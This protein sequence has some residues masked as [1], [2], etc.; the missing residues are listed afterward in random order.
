MSRFVVVN[1]TRETKPVSEKGFGLPLMLA[2][3]KELD[4]KIYT[5][6]SEVAADFAETTREYKLASRMFG[7]S[8][9]IAELAC[10]GTSYVSE[11]DDVTALT[12][13]LNELVQI[14]N[15]FFYLV[16]PEN[17]DKEIKALAEWISTQE[18]FYGVT[19]QNVALVD[20]LK[21][22]YENTFLSVH[23]DP[24]A[25][26]AEGLIA[27]SAPKEIG[28]YTWTFKQINGVRA[29][30][31][32]NTELNAVLNNNATTCIN[33]MGILLNASGKVL[34]GDYIDVVQS[35]YYLRA[36]LREDVFRKLAM[37]EKIPY[38][39]EGIAQIVDVMD[40]R[41]K[42]AFRQG[43]IATNDVGEP[44][45]TIT[46]PLRSEI[47]KNTIAKRILPDIKFRLVIS[48]AVEKVEINGV[49]T[50]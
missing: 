46:Y 41:F 44:D 17:G 9:K 12:S 15:E 4:F 6:I 30:K 11:A 23:D 8:P 18:K 39:N 31:L 2:T 26:H 27:Q 10:Y 24:D 21:G 43:I 42:S 22:M 34:S 1:I 37:V 14:N 5:D 47:P 38:T 20:E 49:L 50:L 29:A 32:T 35:D 25:F 28:S 13:T 36:R 45:Y 19:T 3:S 48:G 7:Q 16:C 40:S 33:E